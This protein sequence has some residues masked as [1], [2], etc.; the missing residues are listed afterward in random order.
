[1]K[2]YYFIGNLNNDYLIMLAVNYVYF[3][4]F[5][6]FFLI[7][8]KVERIATLHLR[9]L[10]LFKLAHISFFIFYF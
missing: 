1:M 4:R 8:W 7:F 10:S 2:V 9:Y 5:N 6:N 3:S